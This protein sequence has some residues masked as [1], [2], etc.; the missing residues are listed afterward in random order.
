[1]YTD[2]EHRCDCGHVLAHTVARPFAQGQLRCLVCNAR[3]VFQYFDGSES[4]LNPNVQQLIY[5]RVVWS[6]F[7][8]AKEVCR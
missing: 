4:K 8:N 1:M 3:Y 2:L 6:P 5:N 7:G